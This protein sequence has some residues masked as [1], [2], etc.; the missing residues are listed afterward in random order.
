MDKVFKVYKGIVK[1]IQEKDFTMDVIVSTS[2]VDRDREKISVEA[3]KKRLKYY[4]DHPVLVSSHRYDDLRKQI[5]EATSVKV[6]DEG[7]EAKFKYYVGEGNPEAD[8]AWVLAQKGIAGFSIGFIPFAYVDKDLEKD[9]YNREYTDVE[10]VEISQVLVPSNRNAVQQ[11]RDIV[12]NL[13]EVEA[14]LLDIAIKSFATGDLR[15]LETKP[16]PQDNETEEHFMNRCI[17]MLV[18]E[19]NKPDQ[20][21]AIC[22]S[23]FDK[24]EA[25]A[26]FR[27]PD[28]SLTITGY[29]NGE[30]TGSSYNIEWNSYTPEALK[31]K[32]E[33]E[34]KYLDTIVS[35]VIE[36]L[37]ADEMFLKSILKCAGINPDAQRIKFEM[38]GMIKSAL[39]PKESK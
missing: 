11:R 10:L 14:E 25:F 16:K 27:N 29:T 21:A 32:E 9:G 17:P 30:S 18:G 7:L 12:K 37:K 33:D 36:K 22:H 34:A 6:T 26:T 4:K 24:K 31:Q 1:S 38:A 8:W 13:N 35:K 2:D 28:G 39:Q 5:G 19:G 3:F 20:A 15:E 23:L